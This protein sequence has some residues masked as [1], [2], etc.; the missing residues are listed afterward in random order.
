MKKAPLEWY[1]VEDNLPTLCLVKVDGKE[2]VRLIIKYENDLFIDDIG[3]T[4]KSAEKLENV[5][6]IKKNSN[7]NKAI[8]EIFDMFDELVSKPQ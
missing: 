6:L 7:H 4:Y 2:T 1:E 5:T 8:S 3:S